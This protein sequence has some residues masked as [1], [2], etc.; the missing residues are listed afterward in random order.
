MDKTPLK[1]TKRVSFVEPSIVEERHEPSEL[2]LQNIEP[3]STLDDSPHTKYEKIQFIN[4]LSYIAKYSLNGHQES[5]Q[6]RAEILSV[7]M[8]KESLPTI[9]ENNLNELEIPNL[10]DL[11][12]T[13]EEEIHQ[14]DSHTQASNLPLLIKHV[15]EFKNNGIEENRQNKEKCCNLIKNRFREIELEIEENFGIVESKINNNYDE[16]L[17]KIQ[18]GKYCSL[19]SQQSDISVETVIEKSYSRLTGS[20]GFLNNLNKNCSFLKTPEVKARTQ[21]EI[22]RRPTLLTPSTMSN[23][24]QEQLNRLNSN[25]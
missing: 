13:Q 8:P 4:A 19:Q 2:A 15:E 12:T 6:K 24:L 14:S 23:V 16:L 9:N 17:K 18:D 7:R 20:F 22:L 25:T 10:T 21:E 1:T 5:V 11:S 3:L